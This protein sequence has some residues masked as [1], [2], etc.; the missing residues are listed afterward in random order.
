MKTIV[1]AI[2][3]ILVPLIIG[4]VT[5]VLTKRK[6]VE[7]E[8]K[9][10]FMSRRINA[11][12]NIHAFMRK[13]SLVI[14][15]PMYLEALYSDFLDGTGFTIGDQQMEYSSYFDDYQRLESYVEELSSLIRD[16]GVYL[17]PSL[18]NELGNMQ[19]WYK[20]VMNLLRA[21]KRTEADETWNIPEESQ[22]IKLKLGCNLLGIAL[23]HDINHFSNSIE[24]KIS[25]K[26]RHPKLE[27]WYEKETDEV[28]SDSSYSESQLVTRIGEVCLLLVFAHIS[29]KYSRDEFDDLDDEE[30]KMIMNEFHKVFT[31][32]LSLK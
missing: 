24:E 15:P 16:A 32:K 2:T 12:S 11:Y 9:R 6:E 19:E 18:R 29:D 21:F 17:E 23:Q 14:A 8:V 31:D 7:M 1:A 26:L 28:F 5:A 4:Y 25:D 22:N 3:Y 20:D 13:S 10:D 27:N 30:R